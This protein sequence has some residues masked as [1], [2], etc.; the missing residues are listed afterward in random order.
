MRK[1]KIPLIHKI[2]EII[3]NYTFLQTGSKLNFKN[4]NK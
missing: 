2:K 3:K 4:K 1:K